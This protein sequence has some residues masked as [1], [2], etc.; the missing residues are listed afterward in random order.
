MGLLTSKFF[1]TTKKSSL[2]DSSIRYLRHTTV[3]DAHFVPI[4]R[5]LISQ[6]SG[7][8]E[9]PEDAV[10]CLDLLYMK[11][12]LWCNINCT[13]KYCVCVCF[14]LLAPEFGI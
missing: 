2:S 14:K 12:L 11:H 3:S 9:L 5:V 7:M 4:F 6:Y 1:L 10:S 8:S 13:S